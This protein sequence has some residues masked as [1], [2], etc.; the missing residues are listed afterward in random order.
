M[1]DAELERRA[2][3]NAETLSGALLRALLIA[4]AVF[5]LFWMATLVSLVLLLVFAAIVIAIAFNGPVTWLE[6]RRVPRLAGMLALLFAITLVTSGI[7]LLVGSKVVEQVAVLADSAPEYLDGLERRSDRLFGNYP[8]LDRAFEPNKPNSSIR[9]VLPQVREVVTRV[10]RFSLGV[11]ALIVLFITW[12]TIV[13]YLVIEPRSLLRAM[14]R[15]APVGQRYAVERTFVA[16]SRM[17]MGWLWANVF[18]GVTEGA[19]VAGFLSWVNVPGAFVWAVLASISVFI[20]K[21]GAW[22]MALPPFLITIATDPSLAIWV[23][24][25][26]VVMNE[27]MSDIVL[28][29]IQSRGM[30][31][32]PAYLVIFLL[33]FGSAFGLLGAVVAT[34]FAGMVAAIWSEFVLSRRPPVADLEARVGRM[35]RDQDE[36]MESG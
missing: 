33:A 31:V 19:L 14:L 25:F 26:Y 9:A 15:L 2:R 29:R 6:R 24:V 4:G 34:P 28:P 36:P 7:G 5:T 20:P 18:A 22:I 35:L 3:E 8:E 1:A 16:F 27:V 13:I 12:L 30:D 23:V 10:G 21:I 11:A 17:V 32:H